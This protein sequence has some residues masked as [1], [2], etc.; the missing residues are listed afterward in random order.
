M[1]SNSG[2]TK[3]CAHDSASTDASAARIPSARPRASTGIRAAGRVTSEASTGGAGL[4]PRQPPSQSCVD[5]DRNGGGRHGAQANGDFG[6]RTSARSWRVRSLRFRRAPL[7]FR[8]FG[9]SGE[10]SDGFRYLQP[11]EPTGLGC[12]ICVPRLA[13]QPSHD[14]FPGPALVPARAPCLAVPL[15]WPCDLGACCSRGAACCCGCCA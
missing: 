12:L 8:L 3:P 4:R 5:G 15:S 2:T 7:S 10:P 9:E 11:Q 1:P 6:R 13:D 14:P